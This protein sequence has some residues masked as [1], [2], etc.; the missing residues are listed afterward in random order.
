M[1]SIT[2]TLTTV[3]V[4]FAFAGALNAEQWSESDT[5]KAGS[6]ASSMLSMSVVNLREQYCGGDSTKGNQDAK[7]AKFIG[8]MMY[9]LGVIDMFREWQKIDPTHALPVCVPRNV[10]A[11]ALIIVV[12]DYIEATA[13]WREQQ[14]DATTAVIG[15]LK[16]KW[17]CPDG[18]R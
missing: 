18:R 14:N 16:A 6:E 13:P 11:G 3:I 8:C 15:A 10:T 4:G 7:N 5:F 12:H 2:K 9:V 17:P 1:S